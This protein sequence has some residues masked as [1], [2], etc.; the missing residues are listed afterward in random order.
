MILTVCPHTALD[1]I[2][3]IDE[4]IPGTPMR[5]DRIVNCVGGKALDSAV[6]LSQLG[7]KTVGIG[8]FAGKIGQELLDLVNGYGIEGVPVWV[9]G[10]NRIAYVIAERKHNRHSHVIAGKVLISEKQKNQL[11]EKYRIYL[12]RAKWVIFAGSL[13]PDINPDFYCELI[14]IAQ[15]QGVPCLVDTQKQYM[16]EAVK[17]KPEIV[18][19]NCEEF[20]WTFGFDAEDLDSLVELAVT[21]HKQNGLKN[22]VLTLSKEGI[23]AITQEGNY[24]AKA[25]FQ[26]PVNAAGAGDAVSSTLVW[27]LLK[28]ESWKTAMKWAGA[29]SAA[30]VLTERTGDVHQED[31][32]RIFPDVSVKEIK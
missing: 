17:A 19:M 20:K 10:E 31:I 28:G 3:F 4:W 7:V 14:Q 24:L 32:N 15:E 11:I 27:R 22:L 6:V 9:N 8:F 25:P 12:D 13:P 21:F 23:L 18:K 2:L 30:A 26:K 16:I 1:K 29:V 5:T